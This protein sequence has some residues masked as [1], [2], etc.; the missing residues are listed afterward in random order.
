M[1]IEQE[2]IGI[3]GLPTPLGLWVT[4]FLGILAIIFLWNGNYKKIM[5]KVSVNSPLTHFMKIKKKKEKIRLIRTTKGKW[6]INGN[7]VKNRGNKI[8][9]N[10]IKGV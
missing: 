4:L 2:I 7:Y 5:R 10:I 9:S 8:I 6:K 3:A 1:V